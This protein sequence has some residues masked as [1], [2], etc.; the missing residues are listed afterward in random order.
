MRHLALLEFQQRTAPEAMSLLMMHDS[1][2]KIVAILLEKVI[3]LHETALTHLNL[4][5]FHENV[6]EK[7]ATMSRLIPCDARA[8]M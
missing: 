4:R 5:E 7:A 6:L 2:E 8:S 3:E 1:H